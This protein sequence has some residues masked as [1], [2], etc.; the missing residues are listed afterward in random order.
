MFSKGQG[1]CFLFVLIVVKVHILMKCLW[2][3]ALL[4]PADRG[5]YF[6]PWINCTSI[7]RVI[8]GC[9]ECLDQEMNST[10]EIFTGPHS[11][12]L[13]PIIMLVILCFIMLYYIVLFLSS[14]EILFIPHPHFFMPLC[15]FFQDYFLEAVIMLGCSSVHMFISHLYVFSGKNVWLGGREVGGGLRKEGTYVYPWQI[16]VNVWQK[17]WQYF[18]VIIL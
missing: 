14:L 10:L 12:I 11:Y 5:K 1:Q 18:K 4:E 3:S 7:C 2:I 13:L 9:P 16:H 6:P 8:F 15:R 17:P